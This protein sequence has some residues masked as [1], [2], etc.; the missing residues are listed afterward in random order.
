M[1]KDER[2]IDHIARQ[3]TAKT[4][5]SNWQAAQSRLDTI[6]ALVVQLQESM[7]GNIKL[8]KEHIYVVEKNISDLKEHGNPPDTSWED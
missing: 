2:L 5:L 6:V 8:L 1:N 3:Q 7:F 4:E